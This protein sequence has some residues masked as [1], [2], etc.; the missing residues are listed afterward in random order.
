MEDYEEAASYSARLDTAITRISTLPAEQ[1]WRLME[2]QKKAAEEAAHEA[3]R[4]Q[5][6]QEQQK[7]ENTLDREQKMWDNNPPKAVGPG[8]V[9]SPAAALGQEG[10]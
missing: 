4:Q 7:L 5:I 9:S 6:G 3:N 10:E 8:V 1:E 2:S